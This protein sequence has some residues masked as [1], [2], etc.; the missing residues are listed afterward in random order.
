MDSS[1]SGSTTV[2]LR[3]FEQAR[4]SIAQKLQT[5]KNQA[6]LKQEMD[7]YK[8]DVR[9]PDFFNI[10]K[11]PSL[12]SPSLSGPC[13][14]CADRSK[15]SHIEASFELAGRSAL[16]PVI[17]SS[18]LDR[19]ASRT[20]QSGPGCVSARIN[21]S[22]RQTSLRDDRGTP[23]YAASFIRQRRIVLE[24][25]LALP[26][27]PLLRFIFVH[28]VFHF[29][30]V[31]LGNSS[32]RRILQ[33]LMGELRLTARGE[34]GESSAVKKAEL[35]APPE[36]RRGSKLWR[37]YICESFC[38]SA[39]CILSAGPVHDGAKLGKRWTA[40]GA[41]G[42]WGN[43]ADELRWASLALAPERYTG[44]RG[45]LEPSSTWFALIPVWPLLTFARLYTGLH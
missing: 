10:T 9:D 22:S 25:G 20:E 23:V 26:A 11:T 32:E 40:F 29:A 43:L 7:K 35:R 8:L 14:Q 15:T 1:F 45:T 28:E 37:D 3:T 36:F 27:P 6:A 39:A 5:D 44:E 33:L 24:T 16:V 13:F 30:W 21:C 18:H 42:S 38:D 34:L 4:A 17:Y 19:I 12:M 41:N 2:S 31:R